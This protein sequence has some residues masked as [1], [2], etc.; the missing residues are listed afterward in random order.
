MAAPK[1]RKPSKKSPQ[2]DKVEKASDKQ[3]FAELP[4]ALN[5]KKL[6]RPTLYDEYYCE[7]VLDMGAEGKSKAQIAALLG[8]SRQCMNEWEKKHTEFGDAL[9]ASQDLALAWWETAGQ[10]N[11]TRQGFN[12]TAFI[13]QMKNRFR[14]EYR[15]VQS[16]EH[17]GKDG[18]AIKVENSTDELVSR[19]ARLASRAGENGG[20][21]RDH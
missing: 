21:R 3:P 19:I 9:K 15:D 14:A 2:T 13:F 10:T 4:A 18:E 8:I 1:K 17:T 16:L 11:M 12:A 7:L 20:T 6:G 5:V